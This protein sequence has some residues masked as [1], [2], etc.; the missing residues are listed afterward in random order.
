MMIRVNDIEYIIIYDL[1]GAFFILY[2]ESRGN[3]TLV[4]VNAMATDDYRI[5]TSVEH[6][7]QID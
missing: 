6:L 2:V 5:S 4:N 3:I 1:N 7:S